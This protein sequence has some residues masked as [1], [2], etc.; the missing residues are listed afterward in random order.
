VAVRLLADLARHGRRTWHLGSIGPA[1]RGV[2]ADDVIWVAI[3]AV[4][5]LDIL[6]SRLPDDA[7]T[8]DAEILRERVIDSWAL[9]LLRRARGDE[10]P[11]P[12]AVIFPASTREVATVLAWASETGMAVIPGGL[13]GHDHHVGAAGR[14]TD[15]S[16]PPAGSRLYAQPGKGGTGCRGRA[17]KQLPASTMAGPAICFATGLVGAQ[18]AQILH[19]QRPDR[20]RARCPRRT[21]DQER[22]LLCLISAFSTTPHRLAQV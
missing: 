11:I 14:V 16:A 6:V 4:D 5:T 12:A 19:G 8:I 2:P 15:S 3:R 17:G 7:V 10:L 21:A 1:R 18:N 13:A 9:A 20:H 22:R